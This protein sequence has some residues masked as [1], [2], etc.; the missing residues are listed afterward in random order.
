MNI[1]K[2]KRYSL[3]ELALLIIFMIGL[4]LAWMVVQKRSTIVLTEPIGLTG[5]GLSVSLPGGAGWEYTP[6]WTYENDN[7]MVLAAQRAF[8]PQAVVKM[9]WRFEFCTSSPTLKEVLTRRLAQSNAS[10]EMLEMPAETGMEAA[11]VS[12][13]DGAYMTIYL[14]A[15]KNLDFGRAVELQVLGS[16]GIDPLYME[17]LLRKTSS[18]LV[19]ETPSELAA[20]IELQGRFFSTLGAESF[21]NEAFL[22]TDQRGRTTGFYV[23]DKL[24]ED[25]DISE[26][27]SR[28]YDAQQFRIDSTLEI[29]KLAAPLNWKTDLKLPGAAGQT[30]HI[31]SRQEGGLVVTSPVG[32]EKV[33]MCSQQHLLPEILLTDFVRLL[34]KSDSG[35][36]IV[37]VLSGTGMVVPVQIG[38]I[39][40]EQAS[41][42][43]ADVATAVRVTYLHGQNYVDELYYNKD[44]EL[45]GRFE[46]QPRRQDRLWDRSGL[47]ELRHIFGDPLNQQ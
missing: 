9:T 17:D 46:R 29:G 20:G 39:D 18:S 26:I 44:T 13:S 27:R 43:S 4:L 28:H 19:Y 30:Y 5:S 14:V 22:I 1:D 36:V 38:R 3:A 16:P 37:D 8:S 15:R 11:R 12:A 45:I 41:A 34:L 42:Q 2:V 25:R 24:S 31:R 7:S 10:V 32:Q 33:I 35:Q 23:A 21:E 47:N 40:R 6:A